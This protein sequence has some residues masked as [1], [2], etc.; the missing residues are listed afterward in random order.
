MQAVVK[1]DPE[2]QI[3]G[4]LVTLGDPLLQ[5]LRVPGR[6]SNLERL[7]FRS[8]GSGNRIAVDRVQDRAISSNLG[9]V[10]LE[11]SNQAQERRV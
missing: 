8:Q 11:C 10:H 9:G 1:A 5:L 7:G 6:E 2:L 3:L 4:P